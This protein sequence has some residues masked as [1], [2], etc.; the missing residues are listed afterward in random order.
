MEAAKIDD[1][2]ETVCSLSGCQRE[3]IRAAL[4][5]ALEIARE[6]RE[7][8]RVGTLFTIGHPDRVLASS[9]LLIL[10]PLAGHAPRF[11]HVADPRL[12]GTLKALA[13][14]DG[15]FVV[16]EDGTVLSGGRYIDVP[17]AD[18]DIPLG[19]GTRHLAA[20]AISRHVDVVAVAVSQTGI[21]RLF[22]RGEII[23][24]LAQ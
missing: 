9:R 15:A 22:W 6:G 18:V 19:L 14:L 3:V 21:V 17:T 20:A 2:L 11:T 10:D 8:K 7:G 23:A 4:T 24:T 12:R 13:Q 1:V 5:L 16:A